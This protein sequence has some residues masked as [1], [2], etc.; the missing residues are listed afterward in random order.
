[1][2]LQTSNIILTGTAGVIETINQIGTYSLGFDFGDIAN[3]TLEGVTM[4]LYIIS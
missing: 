4:S 3:N 1:M 2:Q